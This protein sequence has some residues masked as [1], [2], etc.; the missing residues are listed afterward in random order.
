MIYTQVTAPKYRAVSLNDA[1]A[2]LKTSGTDDD[3]RIQTYIDAA[4]QYVENFTGRALITQ[5]WDQY[6]DGFPWAALVLAKAPLQSV[7]S[8]TYSDSDNATQTLG[9]SIYT[10]DANH[11]PGR[12]YLAYN[13]TWPTAAVKPKAVKVEFV[14]GYG[15]DAASVPESLKQAI[16]LRTQ[17]LYEQPINYDYEG[18]DNAVNAL[19]MPY[20]LNYQI[21]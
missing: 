6:F 4:I 18:L 3:A 16:L 7:S 5:T 1:K 19:L 12:V 15:D 11:V 14:A 21:Q 20:R 17:M 10:V 8:I 13:Q 9:T 2:H